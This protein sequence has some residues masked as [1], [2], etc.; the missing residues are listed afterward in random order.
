VTAEAVRLLPTD[1]P[2]ATGSGEQQVPGAG[3]DSG[4][5][6]RRGEE[7]RPQHEHDVTPAER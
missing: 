1:R 4:R 7:H 3:T 5:N 2:A 6:R